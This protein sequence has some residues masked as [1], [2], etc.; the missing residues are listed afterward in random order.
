MNWKQE[1][2]RAVSIIP[3]WRNKRKMV[4][5]PGVCNS[6]QKNT[7]FRAFNLIIHSIC[8][9]VDSKCE[10][11]PKRPNESEMIRRKR[12][13][14]I[15]PQ[16]IE[17]SR[18]GP[19]QLNTMQRWC[20]W[21]AVCCNETPTSPLYGIFVANV[22]S[23]L[24]RRTATMCKWCSTKICHW[25][26]HVW[27]L[28]RNRI[29]H[30][31]IDVGYSRIPSNRIGSVKWIFAPNIWKKMN[32]IVSDKRDSIQFYSDWFLLFLIETVHVWDYR[33]YAV[34]HAG[35]PPEKELEFSTE[36]IQQN[37][38]NYSS[39]H[40][41]SK[42]LPLLYPHESDKSRP[43]NETV[44]RDELELVLTAAFTDPNDSSAWFY[45]RWL[46]GMFTFEHAPCKVYWMWF[47]PLAGNSEQEL[48]LA[49]FKLT[50]T[51]ALLAFSKPVDLHRCSLSLDATTKF[52]TNKWHP[53]N[54]TGN[55]Y[56]S[57]WKLEDSFEL[58]NESGLSFDLSCTDENGNIHTMPIT[59]CNDGLFGIKMPRFG[60]EFGDSVREL[61][62]EQ[63]SSC[64]QLLEFE[65]ESKC[66]FV[67]KW[68]KSIELN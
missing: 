14:H 37:F 42:L 61:L 48:D 13:R 24:K 38:S 28:I 31:I 15:E 1:T 33:R 2:N 10:Q 58:N 50:K 57:V 6:K 62:I 68:Q 19:L 32:A 52:D 7:I 63:L 53:V 26:V 16:W 66:T 11:V 21:R 54:K 59:K 8:S 56:D 4:I 60:Y 9:T 29:V 41:R 5:F 35:I 36:K 23:N 49:A 55:R 44:L 47:V 34:A 39:W 12:W 64:K 25:P 20:N 46:L 22:C 30:G 18:N 65:P 67:R 40:A 27:K 17:Y 3:W 51:Y 45:Q 43:I